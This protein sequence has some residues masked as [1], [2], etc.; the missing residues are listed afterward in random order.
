MVA[1]SVTAALGFRASGVH[2]GIKQDGE[3]DLALVAADQ[4]V[5]A[6]GVFTQNAAAAAP[7]SLARHHLRHG[8]ARAVVLNSGCANACTGNEGREDA[9]QVVAAIAGSLDCRIE[10][11]LP[12]STGPI[13]TRLP[14]AQITAAV[15]ELVRALAS[16]GGNAARAIL[17]TDSR[18][19]EVVVTGSGWVMG[20]MA[21]GAGMLRP[22]LA[23][24]L[25]VL[26]T[27]AIAEAAVMGG[28]LSEAAAV[29]FNS[30][31][32]DGC[33]S[34][35]DAV[36]LLASGRSGER[37]HADELGKRLEETCRSLARE[38]AADAEGATRVVTLRMRGAPD[39]HSASRLG[40]L[41]ADSALVRASFFGG[42][43]NWGRI[44][45]ALGSAGISPDVVAVSYQGVPVAQAGR[46]VATQTKLDLSGDFV[47]DVTVGS[48]PGSADVI[49]TDLTPDYVL[50][51][52]Q[53]S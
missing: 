52:G 22:N 49:T 7:V 21:K 11:V 53:P 50:F 35:N 2:A 45:A 18:K 15:P 36:L 9:L 26:T 51:N 47:V 38:L 12:C 43:P 37:P 17:T 4:P 6:V 13:G 29:T 20:G 28:L 10:E 23:T 39:D 16:D 1:L 19:K 40:R 5:P 32:V 42:D 24:M 30:L 3:T 48:S 8:R 33:E 46:A 34:T 31:N 27:D 25:V 14:V 41:I 44:V